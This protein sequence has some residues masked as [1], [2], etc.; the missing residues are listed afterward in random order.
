MPRPETAVA[1]RFISVVHCAPATRAP[2]FGLRY[3]RNKFGN[4]IVATGGQRYKVT[5]P[6]DGGGH[7][8]Q[9]IALLAQDHLG[10]EYAWDVGGRAGWD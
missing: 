4:Y 7:Q 2:R 6:K 10:D 1:L 5:S 3:L 9:Y 8:I